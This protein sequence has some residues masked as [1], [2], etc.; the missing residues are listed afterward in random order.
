MIGTEKSIQLLLPVAM[1]REKDINMLVDAL[2]TIDPDAAASL[3]QM[4]QGL[5]L[6]GRYM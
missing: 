5:V 1:G 3:H 6:N 2:R 4:L